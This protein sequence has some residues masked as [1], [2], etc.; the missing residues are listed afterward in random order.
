METTDSN[1][2]NSSAY[3][4]TESGQCVQRSSVLAGVMLL[5]LWG[6]Q[7]L[8]IV[9]EVKIDTVRHMKSRGEIPGVV[10]LNMRKW[11][12]HRDA[13]LEH[14]KQRGMPQA[15]IGLP[16]GSKTTEGPSI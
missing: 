3:P 9:L 11:F 5:P 8:A 4:N 6:E 2:R 16:R 12:V 1:P 10:N 15:S 14:I 13:F 7:E